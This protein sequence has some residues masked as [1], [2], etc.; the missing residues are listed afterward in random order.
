MTDL[1]A[2]IGSTK[3]RF[4]LV[5]SGLGN[6]GPEAIRVLSVQS[7]RGLEDAMSGYLEA[8]NV[9]PDAIERAAICIAGPVLGDM[10]VMTNHP[11]SFSQRDIR[12]QFGLNDLTVI[13]DFT[14][15]ALSLPRLKKA[16]RRQIGSGEAAEHAH[17]AVLGPGTGLGVS[18]L[19]HHNRNRWLP[20]SGEG[21]HVT[22]A[23]MTEREAEVIDNQRRH[24]GHVC[25]EDFLCGRGLVTLYQAISR[26]DGKTVTGRLIPA[27]VT[28]R[29]LEGSD[30]VAV[31]TVEMFCAFLGNVAGNLALTI[32]ATGGVYIA[33]GIIPRL[34]EAFD[35]SAFRDRFENKGRFI[36]YLKPI[37]TYLVTHEFPAFLG[38]IAALSATDN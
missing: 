28:N 32:G 19:I 24:T 2:D 5:G 36:D 30:P 9:S 16:D 25:G 18:G 27:D 35:R 15:M 13:N 3:A 31:E 26:T 17:K 23:G 6:V 29:A 4:A 37:P 11:W 14:A 7:Y 20:L 22:L 1:I 21:G 8:I 34:G 12:D 38:L 10:I 33:G